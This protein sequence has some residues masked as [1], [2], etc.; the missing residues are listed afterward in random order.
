MQ[1]TTL[2]GRGQDRGPGGSYASKDKGMHVNAI[3]EKENIIDK[4][5]NLKR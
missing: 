4:I 1:K 3:E 5:I 2:V